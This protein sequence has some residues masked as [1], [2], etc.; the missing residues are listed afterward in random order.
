MKRVGLNLR[1]VLQQRIQDMD[2]FPHAAGDEAGEQGDVAVG[3]VVVRDAAITAVADMARTEQV[4]LAQ[5]DVR[6]VSDRGATAA[7][8]PRQLEPDILTD[9]VDHGGFQ[10]VGGD[11]LRI[12]PPQRLHPSR[13]RA[14]GARSG[15]G[16]D[17]S[18]SRTR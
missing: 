12:D 16:Q 8:M 4:V 9:H 7:P 11:V 5:L 15:S 3:N 2:C 14:R 1:A 6:S 18:R 10:L 13:F 17:C